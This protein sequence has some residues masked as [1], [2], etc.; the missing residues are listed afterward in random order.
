MLK[1][2][3]LPPGRAKLATN[4]FVTGSA[5]TTETIGIVEVAFFAASTDSAADEVG[6]QREQSIIMT[7]RPAIFGRHVL[8][9]DVAGLAQSLTER[10]QERLCA[11]GRD[12]AE[13]ANHGHRLLLRA[14]G[15]R[16]SA[17]ER[18]EEG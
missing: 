2:V 17:C 6:G 12:A 1:P 14:D 4:P 7:V 11:L 9:F 16:P 18:A 13:P 15:E 5:P 10:G 3:R 8:T